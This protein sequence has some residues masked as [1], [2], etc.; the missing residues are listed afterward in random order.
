MCNPSLHT[1]PKLKFMFQ[2]DEKLILITQIIRKIVYLFIDRVTYLL[3]YLPTYLPTYLSIYLSIYRSICLSIK[4]R[5]NK[6]QI[7]LSI[8]KPIIMEM[9][10]LEKSI[11]ICRSLFSSARWQ[12]E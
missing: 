3:S 11:E 8:F 7:Y 5:E 2:Q 10:L 4:E 6:L 12:F 9:F 1:F